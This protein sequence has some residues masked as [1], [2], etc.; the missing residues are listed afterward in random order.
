MLK[1]KPGKETIKLEGMA[2]TFLTMTQ[3]PEAI[4]ETSVTT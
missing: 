1:N 2:V 4:E 3:N